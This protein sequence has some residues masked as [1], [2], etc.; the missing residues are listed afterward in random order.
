MDN[1]R[2]K[3]EEFLKKRFP[4][5]VR[6]EKKVDIIQDIAE[7]IDEVEGEDYEDLPSREKMK[8][9]HRQ[10]NGRKIKQKVRR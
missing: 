4:H 7:S 5:S 2:K 10:N 6:I 9:R 8:E 1:N 3:V